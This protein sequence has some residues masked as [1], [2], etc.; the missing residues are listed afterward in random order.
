MGESTNSG[1]KLRVNRR[2]RMEFLGA[3][4]TSDA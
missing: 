2:P 3:T 1:F 4:I